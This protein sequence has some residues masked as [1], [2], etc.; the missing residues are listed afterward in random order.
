MSQRSLEQV[1][2]TVNSPVELLRNSQ[3]GPYA[4]PV[5]RHEFTNWRDEQRSWRETCALFDQSHHMTDLY[6]EGPEALR[7]LTT[8]GVNSFKG[9]KVDQAKQFIACNDEGYV[10]GDAIL[11]FLEE[12]RGDTPVPR[13]AVHRADRPRGRGRR[14]QQGEQRERGDGPA[15]AAGQLGA[16]R[17]RLE[18]RGLA[19]AHGG[20]E[21]GG[22][23]ALFHRGQGAGDA[24]PLAVVPLRDSV[25]V[26]DC[27]DPAGSAA[28]P[29]PCVAARTVDEVLEMPS[30][31]IGSV[32]EIVEQMRAGRSPQ[33]ACELA[34][35]RINEVAV[36]RGV[37]VAQFTI[38]RDSNT[39]ELTEK[40]AVQLERRFLA[41]PFMVIAKFERK[42]VDANRPRADAYE[43]AAAGVYYDAYHEALRL[44]CEQVRL[45]WGG[46]VML[47]IHGHGAEAGLPGVE[48][49]DLAGRDAN[50][51]DRPT[52]FITHRP[53]ARAPARFRELTRPVGHATLANL[54]SIPGALR[55]RT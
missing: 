19:R 18:Q 35:R 10:I 52:V 39:A 44:A 14:P 41:K 50:R 11:F 24:D 2:Q 43:S 28:V 1:L 21:Q 34:V 37:G 15:R 46:G 38:E 40:I 23:V 20:L 51:G 30:V 3:I 16:L 29:D 9:F 45:N 8:L 32:D 13:Q 17:D 22:L 25:A 49:I 55:G 27:A 6:V 26:P 12:N 42:Y 53:A 7:L 31:F 4:F 36:R 54:E 47:D 48:H 5:V 33:E